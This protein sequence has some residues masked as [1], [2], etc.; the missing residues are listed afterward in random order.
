MKPLLN[1]LLLSTLLFVF[2]CKTET[3]EPIADPIV[4]EPVKEWAPEDTRTITG[5]FSKRGLIKNTD[6]AT[7]GYILFNP[8]SSTHTYLMN[9]QGE[10][11]H[12]WSGELNSMQAYLKENGNLV[13]LERDPDFPVFAAGGQGGRVREYTW[14]G[15]MIWDFKYATDK[16]LTHHDI[17]LLPNGNIL[18]IAYEVKSKAE[19]IAAGRDPEHI[20]VAGVWPD[21]I[22]EIEPVKP[23]GGKIV[24]EWRMW[25]HLVQDK[26]KDKANYGQLSANPRKIN[27]NVFD[28]HGAP[29]PAE[30]IEQL[31]KMGWLTSNASV[32][33][34]D[35]D[36][37]HTNAV[38]YNKKLDQIAFSVPGYCEVFVIDHSTTT[39]EAKGSTG[40][41][42]GHG[43][44][45]LYRWGNPQ[46]YGRGGPEDQVLYYQHDIRWVEDNCP[47]AGNLMVFNNDIPKGEN[48]L[49]NAF[50]AIMQAQTSRSKSKYWRRR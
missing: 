4:E 5:Y 25:D 11:V 37:T 38:A 40:G 21:K 10:I 39:A 7:P 49:P 28:P 19:A 12:R 36:I 1:V 3:K 33:S 8:A 43:G 29:P 42:W 45:L 23:N 18:A 30:Q 46:N 24:W 13:R 34:W 14:D 48:K 17:E 44:D 26:F 16:N 32:D 22:M 35:S 50:V 2:S 15:E 6:K 20:A 47:G 31:K 9:K 27:I 41:R